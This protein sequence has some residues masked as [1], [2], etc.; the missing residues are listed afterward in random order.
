MLRLLPLLV[1]LSVL[2]GCNEL[3][4]WRAGQIK[5]SGDAARGSAVEAPETPVEVPSGVRRELPLHDD[6]T[7]LSYS[8]ASGLP[9]VRAL[10]T[11]D[12]TPI[13]LYLLQRLGELGYEPGDNV[14]RILEGT[15][16]SGRGRYTNLFV[17]V[18]LNT[19]EQTLITLRAD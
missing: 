4:E 15:V 6:W 9:H 1:L 17:R 14:S 3:D 19:S 7:I 12:T 18:E 5:A 11:D 13:A 2:V 16:Y 8:D 10:S